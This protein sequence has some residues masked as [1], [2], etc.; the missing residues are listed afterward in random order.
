M[1]INKMGLCLTLLLTLVGGSGVFAAT[2]AI[3][4]DDFTLTNE[5]VSYEATNDSIMMKL[6]EKAGLSWSGS[7]YLTSGGWC[8][9]IS[10]NNFFSANVEVTNKNGNSGPVTVRII[11]GKGNLLV[12]EEEIKVGKTKRFSGIAWNSGTYIVQA[13]ATTSGFH[14][15]HVTSRVLY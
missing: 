13:K 8:N 3:N 14:A 10:D 6:L 9:V 4:S 15:F 2:H 12:E 7:T 1:K 11:D 5:F